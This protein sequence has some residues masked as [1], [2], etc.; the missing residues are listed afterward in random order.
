MSAKLTVF[1][2]LCAA[3]QDGGSRGRSRTGPSAAGAADG[4]PEEDLHQVDEQRL[5][6]ERGE[7][8]EDRSSTCQ[9][10]KH[11][12]KLYRDEIKL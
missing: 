2:T 11:K 12:L 10:K 6:Q 9:M 1:Q 3:G 5:L 7:T 4:G 8:T